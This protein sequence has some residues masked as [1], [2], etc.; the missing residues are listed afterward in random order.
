MANVSNF[1]SMYSKFLIKDLCYSKIYNNEGWNGDENKPDST[2]YSPLIKVVENLYPSHF[3][4]FT[5]S[6]DF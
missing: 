6:S 3:I 5:P 4:L 1:G 2:H